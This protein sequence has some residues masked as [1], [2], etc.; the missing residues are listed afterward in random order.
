MKQ[1]FNKSKTSNSFHSALLLLCIF[2]FATNTIGQPLQYA[3]LSFSEALAKAKNDNKIVFIN[4]EGS[5][6]PCN[7]VANTA[8]SGNGINEFFKKFVCI[9]VKPDTK[10]YKNIIS[11]YYIPRNLPLSFFLFVGAKGNYLASL[12]NSSALNRNIYFN[13]AKDAIANVENPPLKLYT[14]SL[15]N[16]NIT[17]EL[18]KQYIIKLNERNLYISDLVET[19]ASGLTVKELEDENELKFLITTASVINSRSFKLTRLNNELFQKVFGTI[20]VEERIKINRKIIATSKE[21]A[22]KEKNVSYMYQ[23]AQFLRGTYVN[24]PKQ[25]QKES[26]ILMM[27]YYHGVKDSVQYYLTAKQYYNSYIKSLDIDSLCKAELGELN[28]IKNGLTSKN[29]ILFPIGGQINK[30]AWQLY[31]ISSDEEHLGLALKLSK[32]TLAYNLPH[33][34]DTYAH[35]L[36][37]LGGKKDAIEWQQKAVDLCESSIDPSNYTIKEELTKIRCKCRSV[38]FASIL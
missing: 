38:L 15:L 14:D 10:D 34:I 19:Y 33:F 11:E 16:G 27:D 31:E 32:R 5:C 8:L 37:K 36:Y 22:I 25:A 20:P 28:Q 6:I 18:M 13:L 1:I 29:G 12:Q 3:N 23:V 9:K 24:N 21:K 30:M 26:N 4:I 35:I 7:A 2:C 17:K